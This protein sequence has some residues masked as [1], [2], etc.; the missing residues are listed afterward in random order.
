[1]PTCQLQLWR[2]CNSARIIY[3]RCA[4]CTTSALQAGPE[5]LHTLL[6][7]P[8]CLVPSHAGVQEQRPWIQAFASL[9][10]AAMPLMPRGTTR[11]RPFIYIYDMPPAYTSRML[12]YRIDKWVAAGH[13]QAAVPACLPVYRPAHIMWPVMQA[14]HASLPC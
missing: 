4:V 12:Q 9:P 6:L 7:T 3:S 5:L 1:V 11:K 13:Q 8:G 14:C 2:R 10:P